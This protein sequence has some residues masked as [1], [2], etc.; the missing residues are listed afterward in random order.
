MTKTLILLI[1]L[2]PFGH[3]D[4]TWLVENPGAPVVRQELVKAVSYDA[5]G[6]KLDDKAKVEK[7]LSML[8]TVYPDW[9]SSYFAGDWDC[10]TMSDFVRYYLDSCG[11]QS[12]ME[13]GT[14]QNGKCH[15][16]VRYKDIAVESINLKVITSD[17]SYKNKYFKNRM[18]VFEGDY[19]YH[20]EHQ[21]QGW[22][23]TRYMERKYAEAKAKKLV[24]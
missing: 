13:I 18:T 23:N 17:T 22:Y 19:T 3:T 16:W 21:L 14:A 11:M 24:K 8:K 2:L 15:V 20:P 6:N 5:K 4:P 7:A 9:E 10:D 1:M 12:R